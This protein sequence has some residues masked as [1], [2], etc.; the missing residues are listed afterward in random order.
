MKNLILRI[1]FASFVLLFGC[2]G[3]ESSRPYRIGIDPTFYPLHLRGKEANVFAFSNEVLREIGHLKKIHFERVNMSWDNLLWGLKE[4]KYEAILSAMQPY[5]FNLKKYSFSDIYLPTGPVLVVR[6]GSSIR[7][8]E[9]LNGKD[10]AMEETNENLS[11]LEKYP[12]VITHFYQ[13]IPDVLDQ[14]I[15]G[16][17]EGVLIGGIFAKNY[18]QDLYDGQMTVVTP[19]LTNEGLRL[20]TLHSQ[21]ADLISLFNEGLE[22]LKRTGRYKELLFKWNLSY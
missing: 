3:K 17:M 6:M 11:L 22:E 18:I 16:K 15:K 20:I 8:L 4:K 21:Q 14:L 13:S 9:D 10:L 1:F 7:S 5:V 12:Q 19:P 2:G